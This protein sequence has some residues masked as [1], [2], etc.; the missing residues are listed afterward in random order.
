MHYKSLAL[1]NILAYI[2]LIPAAVWI[3]PYVWPQSDV[4]YYFAV[5]GAGIALM[6]VL[7][8]TEK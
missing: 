5:N 4:T 1:I 2:M 3:G 7:F 8:L 6:N